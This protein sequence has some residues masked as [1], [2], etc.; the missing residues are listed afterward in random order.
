MECLRPILGR[1]HTL[2]AEALRRG[3]RNNNPIFEAIEVLCK[4]PEL[5]LPD[6]LSF[7]DSEG[8]DRH[9]VRVR[10][11]EL[12]ARTFR[13]AAI[14]PPGHA[15]RIPDAP[16]PAEWTGHPYSGPPVL[17]G[18]YWFAGPPEVIP[19]GRFAC[20]DYSVAHA[21]PLVA[22]RWD[23]EKELSTTKMVSV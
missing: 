19:G 13:D 15:H 7:K 9:D 6:G 8:K 2:T 23:G 11:W 1:H 16:L 17:F 21:G 4:G 20:L 3:T 22:Y 12:G 18:H 5:R 10:W 14:V